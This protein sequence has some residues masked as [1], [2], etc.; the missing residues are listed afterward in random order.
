MTQGKR[1]FLKDMMSYLIPPEDQP[2]QIAPSIKARKRGIGTDGHAADDVAP[3][4]P[5]PWGTAPEPENPTVVPLEVL[6][7]FHF[8]FLIR[9]PHSS[10]PS[11]YRCT[12]PPL[13]QSTDW[14]P[15]D[16]L[17][18]GYHELRRGF[19]Y[20]R[21]A[22][23]VGPAQTTK[24]DDDAS[25]TTSEASSSSQV[26]E[27]DHTEICVI[28]ADDLLDDPETII[29]TYCK[30]VGLDFQPSMLTW[31]SEADQQVAEEAFE[32]WKGW[33]DDALESNDLHART[34]VSLGPSAPPVLSWPRSSLTPILT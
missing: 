25:S 31:D 28:D 6:S 16:P 14:T 32:K 2:A 27:T 7:Q 33:H 3:S 10:I 15:F 1:P 12:L 4:T 26:S 29:R 22:A 8:T 18:A 17:D 5:Y 30:S 23:Q 11:F 34:H 24:V 13:V 21:S 20:L 9:N 19:D